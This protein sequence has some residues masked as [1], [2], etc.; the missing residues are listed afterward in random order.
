MDSAVYL[1]V[2]GRHD[3]SSTHARGTLLFLSFGCWERGYYPNFSMYLRGL[4]CGGKE[5]PGQSPNAAR[6][7]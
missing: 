4:E 1:D 7:L 5:D 3:W 6:G 2:T